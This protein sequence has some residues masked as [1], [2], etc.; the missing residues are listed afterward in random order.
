MRTSWPL[1]VVL[2]LTAAA[3]ILGPVW[4]VFVQGPP[5]DYYRGLAEASCKCDRRA[6]GAPDKEACWRAFD[7]AT[8]NSRANPGGTLCYPIS[9]RSV[10]LPDE[11]R[12][13]ITWNLVGSRAFF[14]SEKEAI[15]AEALW[16]SIDTVDTFYLP[17]GEQAA[18]MKRATAALEQLS[19][20][21]ARGE[22]ITHARAYGCVSGMH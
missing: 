6:S 17:Q 9:E 13:T 21:Y 20:D 22:R 14:C 3:A 19:R 16:A 18:V 1:H 2:L 10:H 4:A 5:H 8:D 7:A 11:S 12:L 15:S